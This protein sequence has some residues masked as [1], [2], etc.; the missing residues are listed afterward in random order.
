MITDEEVIKLLKQRAESDQLEYKEIIDLSSEKGWLRL[1]KHII[2][3]ANRNG[4]YMIIGVNDYGKCVGVPPNYKIDEGK[5]RDKLR[6]YVN[7]IPNFLCRE[8]VDDEGRRLIIIKVFSA[9][10]VIIPK[11]PGIINSHREFDKGAIIF[12]VGSQ[13]KI[14][15][16]SVDIRGFIDFLMFKKK[17]STERK[18]AVLVERMK[19]LSSPANIKETLT[20]N[21]FPV[22]QLPNKVYYSNTPYSNKKEI[23]EAGVMSNGDLPDPFILKEGKLFTFSDLSETSNCLRKLIEN[24]VKVIETKEWFRS[25]KHRRYLIE[26]LNLNMKSYALKMD[27][28]FYSKKKIFYF[29][30]PMD[31]ATY[32]KSNKTIKRRVIRY[33]NKSGY[34]IHHAARIS[35]T[36]IDDSLYLFINPTFILTSDGVTPSR[37]DKAKTLLTKIMDKQFNNIVEDNVNFWIHYLSKGLPVLTIEGMDYTIRISCKSLVSMANFGYDEGKFGKMIKGDEE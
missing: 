28:G 20:S 2:G 22:T 7:V 14:L 17:M 6:K 15:E 36:L 9:E 25:E 27:L 37:D 33:D 34:F 29:K 26:L 12:R 11:K 31:I 21:L 8:Y 10:E 30:P 18:Y 32:R 24:D 13:T 16:D 19:I 35:F 4:G 1:I 3:F 23:W 5:L